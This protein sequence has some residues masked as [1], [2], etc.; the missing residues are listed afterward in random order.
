MIIGTCPYCDGDL[1]IPLAPHC[2]AWEIH[3]CEICGKSIYTYHSRVSPTSY[4][5]KAFLEL[6]VDLSKMRKDYD[7][8]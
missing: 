7:E 4:T 3:D 6:D 5:Q 1:S 8:L 2:P